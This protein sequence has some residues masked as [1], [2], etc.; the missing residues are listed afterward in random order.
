MQ[1]HSYTAYPEE[2]QDLFQEPHFIYASF[3]QRFFA[4]FIDGIILIIPSYIFT[5][6]FGRETLTT[7]MAN[8]I[9]G[10]LYGAAMESGSWQ[11]T[12]GK[13]SMRIKVIDMQG[14]RI[15][16][17]QATGRHFG[18]YISTIILCI[19]YLMMLWDDKK[20]TLHDKMANTLVIEGE[21]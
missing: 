6:I 1:D 10:W 21:A 9:T 18:K 8:I 2:K 17:G 19:G 13:R 15:S 7:Y 20:Q 11:A 16:F 14:Q 5:Y 4:V 3:W 12:V